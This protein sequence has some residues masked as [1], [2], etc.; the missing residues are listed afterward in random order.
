MGLIVFD[1]SAFVGL[2]DRTDEVHPAATDLFTR[3]GSE[4]QRFA[5]SVITWSELGVGAR[6]GHYPLKSIEGLFR[7]AAIEVLD[8]DRAVADRAA[9]LRA[10][11]IK[12]HKRSDLRLPDALILAAA[13]SHPEGSAVVTADR[14]WARVPGLGVDLILL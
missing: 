7:E 13:E 1:T 14:K 9:V 5:A 2:L 11:Y 12:K 4:R 8:V 10:G 3:L 6:L